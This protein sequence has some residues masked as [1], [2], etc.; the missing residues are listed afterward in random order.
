MENKKA[1]Q[2]MNESTEAVTLR[3]VLGLPML[4]F[5]GVGVTIGAGIFALIGEIVRVAGDHAPMAFML[6]GVIAGAT[7]ISY[8][9]LSSVYPRA[10]GEAVYVNICLEA[11]R[12]WVFV[13]AYG[14]PPP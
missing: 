7:G 2:D 4:V 13:K 9:K 14:L 5:Y 8:A 1:N 12:A 11:L 10:G 3:R 6:A